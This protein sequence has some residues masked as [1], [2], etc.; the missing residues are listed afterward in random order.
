MLKEK[1]HSVLFL[2][3]G[4]QL[5]ESAKEKIQCTI[6]RQRNKGAIY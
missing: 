1:I 2:N 6:K 4:I 5:E 3:N